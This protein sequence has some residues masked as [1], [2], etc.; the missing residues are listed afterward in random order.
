MTAHRNHPRW[1]A[2]LCLIGLLASSPAITEGQQADREYAEY[3]FSYVGFTVARGD[4]AVMDTFTAGGQPARR[5]E[6][7]ASSVPVTSFLFRLDNEYITTIDPLTGY[8]LE[9]STRI[10]QSNFAEEST[11]SF[12]R[13][14]GTVYQGKGSAISFPEPVHN[15][16]SALY[17]LFHHTFQP[18]EKMHLPVYAAGQIWN[19]RVEA[20]KVEKVATEAGVCSA[21]LV[22]IAFTRSE[23]LPERDVET[24][25]LTSRLTSEGKKTRLWISTGNRHGMVKGEY[26]LFPAPLQMML[27]SHH[28]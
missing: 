4:L 2:L 11:V 14:N 17:L 15:I 21:V 27:T 7:R 6:V 1:P 3:I 10:A 5:I 9:Y 23:A 24:D 13:K 20:V 19:V 25:V 16:F 8:P 28:R 22:D 26:D 12:D 18:R